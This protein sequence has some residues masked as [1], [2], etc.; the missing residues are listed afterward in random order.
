ML[1]EQKARKCKDKQDSDIKTKIEKLSL[2][3]LTCK[4]KCGIGFILKG[5]YV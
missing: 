5:T 3:K 4:A 1:P 2:K